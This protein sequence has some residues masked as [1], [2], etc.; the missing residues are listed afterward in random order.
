MIRYNNL[1]IFINAGD[2][3]PGGNIG[4]MLSPYLMSTNML[5][6][7]KKFNELTQEFNSEI[8]LNVK[9]SVD[10]LEKSYTFF[11]NL[12]NITLIYFY[13]SKFSFFNTKRV[14]SIL[15]IYDLGR[16]VSF[17][18]N[19]HLVKSC[20]LVLS[21]IKSFRKRRVYLNFDNLFIQKLLLNDN[22]KF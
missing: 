4:A 16:Y 7:C 14:L 9:I 13:F 19:L 8:L 15:K 10:S 5:N 17:C 6:F 20:K 11:I 2:A 12:P 1:K 22:Y 3:K 18:Y 21:I